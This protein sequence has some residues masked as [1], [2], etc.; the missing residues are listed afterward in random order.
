MRVSNRDLQIISFVA[1]FGQVTSEHVR[2]TVFKDNLSQTPCD[3]AMSRLVSQKL[4]ARIEKRTVGGAKGG[5]GQYVYQVGYTAWKM[6]KT[7]GAYWQA[8]AV[9]YHS[10]AIAEVYVAITEKLDVVR[11]ETEPDSHVKINYF[12]LLPD[13][14]MELNLGTKK[15]RVWLEIDLGTERPKQLKDKL[16]RYHQAWNGA[17]D[18]WNPWPFVVFVVPDEKRLREL[19]SLVAQ[20]PQESRLMFKTALF[21]DVVQVVGS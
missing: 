2:R 16:T 9:N 17:G 1:R 15:R 13:L 10:L 21:E 5:S 7:E 19:E 18:T 6:M 20:T 11:F 4:L 3:R 12:P 14:Y 8:R